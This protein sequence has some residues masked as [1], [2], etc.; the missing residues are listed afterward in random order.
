MQHVQQSRPPE[1]WS[2]NTLSGGRATEPTQLTQGMVW[3]SNQNW[4]SHTGGFRTDPAMQQGGAHFQAQPVYRG[5]NNAAVVVAPGANYNNAQMP[6]FWP[7]H[8]GLQGSALSGQP[9]GQSPNLALGGGW[10]NQYNT[11]GADGVQRYMF[12]PDEA[13]LG[14]VPAQA[15]AEQLGL[16]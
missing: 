7:G 1:Q 14:G 15:G 2:Q 3:Q 5:M 6:G 13:F 8:A 11:A 4:Q 10:Q 16:R 9:A 12:E